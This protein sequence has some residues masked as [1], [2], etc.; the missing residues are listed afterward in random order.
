[1]TYV[2]ESSMCA[3]AITSPTD[4]ITTDLVR[5]ETTSSSSSRSWRSSKQSFTLEAFEKRS[6]SLRRT[7]CSVELI[8]PEFIM[9]PPY[10]ND[11]AT[12]AR[13]TEMAT[14]NIRI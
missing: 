6:S 11:I 5:R 8:W 12:H 7:L 2:Q 9:A 13:Y 14:L 10:V 4:H 3:G 1:M